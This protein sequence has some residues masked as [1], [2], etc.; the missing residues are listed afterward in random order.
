MLGLETHMGY[1]KETYDAHYAALATA[2][3][4]ESI[5]PTAPGWVTIFTNAGA[6][7]GAW[8]RP[9]IRAPGEEAHRHAANGK[10]GHHHR[11]WALPGSKQSD[12]WAKLAAEEPDCR[13]VEW[14][15]YLDP[16]EARA[17]SLPRS[18]THLKRE[19]SEKMLA[20][21]RQW[22]GGRTSKTKYRMPKSQW[23]DGTFAGIT[24]RLASRFYQVETGRCR[25]GSTS[26]GRGTGPPR[27][28]GGAA[29][30]AG[31][32]PNL[33]SIYILPI[34]I[35]RTPYSLPRPSGKKPSYISR[36]VL[37]PRRK[38]ELMRGPRTPPFDPAV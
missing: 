4:S 22:A 19:I 25:T 34:T 26:T 37:A 18:L 8:P 23:P 6:V 2:L 38:N 16:D 9:E 29:E 28:A 1:K 33:I 35:I 24:K 21:A 3:E 12:E 7:E 30:A 10:T 36:L 5:R 31:V 15:R 14:Q 17:M 11:D 27:S 32:D 20:E 13:G